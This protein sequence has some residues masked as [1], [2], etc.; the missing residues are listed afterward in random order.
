MYFFKQNAENESL[1]DMEYHHFSIDMDWTGSSSS[2]PDDMD[3]FEGTVKW[4]NSRETSDIFLSPKA[5][6]KSMCS[7]P[8]FFP[9][10]RAILPVSYS[11]L[12]FYTL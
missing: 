1:L 3:D 9:L 2:M 8:S 5:C 6:K 7:I 10:E 4:N 11:K 12:G